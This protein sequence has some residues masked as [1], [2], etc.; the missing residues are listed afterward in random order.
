MG[1]KKRCP[2]VIN[3]KTNARPKKAKTPKHQPAYR[4]VPGLPPELRDLVR[5]M[6]VD[7]A[8]FE[9]VVEAIAESGDTSIPL[10]AIESYFRSDLDIQK[11][12]IKRQ[13]QTAKVL[14][15]ALTDPKSGHTELAEAVLITGL[16][17]VNRRSVSSSLQQAIRVKDQ[18][19]NQSLKEE[20]SRLRIE[21]FAMDKKVL[22]ARLRAEE[23]K[24]ELIRTKLSH[25]Q[26]A[27]E[28]NGEDKILGPEI[29]RQI[30][31][32]YG[33]VSVPNSDTS[34]SEGLRGDT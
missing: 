8:T 1:S 26:Q 25:L 9:D 22:A 6:L 11:E 29:I 21:K 2:T 24:Q 14:R 4:N 32:I 34:N 31:E 27:L 19:A 30:H 15:E 23:T 33:I 12:R 16:M 3:T 10:R 18:H 13:L 7:G 17:G 20:A 28:R 5:Q